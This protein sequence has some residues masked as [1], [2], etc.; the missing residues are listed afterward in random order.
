VTHGIDLGG[1]GRK[2]ITGVGGSTAVQT[3]RRG[4]TVVEQR[5]S[6]GGQ[7]GGR[8]SS[9]RRCRARGGVPEFGGGPGRRFAVVQ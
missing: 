2:E 5:S 7:Q 6:R 3:E 9:R 4:A 8:G 1:S